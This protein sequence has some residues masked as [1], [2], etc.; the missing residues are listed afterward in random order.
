MCH[1]VHKKSYPLFRGVRGGTKAV[2]LKTSKSTIPP[3]NALWSRAGAMGQGYPL[4]GPSPGTNPLINPSSLPLA[5]GN[6][7]SN[8]FPKIH[9]I[10]F[11]SIGDQ[12]TPLLE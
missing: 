1:H 5:S 4:T 12:T 7:V 10:F 2:H 3:P 11:V 6:P 9:G 8:I